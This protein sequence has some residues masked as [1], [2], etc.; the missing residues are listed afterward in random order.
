MS[1]D[2]PKNIAFIDGQ[3]LYK[4]TTSSAGGSW[5]VDLARFRQ[6]LLR[7]YGV[8]KAFYYM[9]CWLSVH[10]D[11]YGKMENAGFVAV[12][13]QH[14]ETMAAKKKGNVDVDIVFDVMLSLYRREDFDR[15][16]LV[17]GD[18]D[19][20]SMV[21]FLIGEGRLRKV[22]APN[23]HRASSLYKQIGSHYFDC[24]DN[25]EIKSKIMEQKR[26]GVLR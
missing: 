1:D 6:Y 7:K 18:G 26:E 2:E 11:L 5:R 23:R 21:D 22:L 9:G 24:L 16:V 17:S 13:R 3:N 15:I 20:K 4:G 14:S 12:F 25:Q 19:Y 8:S 10:R